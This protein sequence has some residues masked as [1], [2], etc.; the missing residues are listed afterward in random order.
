M[1]ASHKYAGLEA[2][3]AIAAL[4]VVYNHVFMFNLVSSNTLLRLPANYAAEAVMIFFVLSGVVITLSVERKKR[5]SLF[6]AKL[7]VEYLR[8]RFLRIYPIMICG[9]LLAVIVERLIDGV[10]IDAHQIAGIALFLQSFPGYIVGVPH[11]NQALWSL[12]YEM[13]YYILF[14]V[15]LL[16][17]RFLGLWFVA[18]LIAAFY[19]P[20]TAGGVASHV[21]SVLG[22][23]IP[24][25][26][27][28]LIAK[29]REYM[30]RMPLSFGVA[31]LVIGLVYARCPLTDGFFDIFRLTSFALCCCPL[32][33]A[34]IQKDNQRYISTERLLFVRI[35]LAAIALLLLWTISPSLFLIKSSLTIAAAAA[36]LVPLTYI[37]KG[38]WLLRW[39]LPGLVYIGSVSYAIYA[40]HEP[41][42]AL[43]VYLG[44][45]LGG[46]SK[47][48]A[49][50]IATL[51]ISYIVERV[52][53]P[54]LS[55]TRRSTLPIQP[56]P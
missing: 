20:S 9:L 45:E 22:L 19:P 14:A 6:G 48:V 51:A 25:I 28:H 44:R 2:V 3:R 7:A 1:G 36:A 23:S 49:F 37:D 52:V 56:M 30:P 39:A 12:S 26:L 35:A 17:G 41:L 8:A 50:S 32:M 47:I 10:W 54:V 31:C 18:A 33:L 21:V 27:G 38:L 46:A 13:S 24:W 53:Q 40:I 16:W 29:W 11:S 43:T 4:I 15:S 34:L 42:I 55:V 5:H